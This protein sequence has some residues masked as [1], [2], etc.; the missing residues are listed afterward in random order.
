MQRGELSEL[1]QNLDLF[2]FSL[3]LI[4]RSH[5][6]LCK[7]CIENIKLWKS[8]NY[9]VMKNSI[10]SEYLWAN[11]NIFFFL[12]K[13]FNCR[14]DN[15]NSFSG[16]K[17]WYST[18]DHAISVRYDKEFFVLLSWSEY[19]PFFSRWLMQKSKLLELILWDNVLYSMKKATYRLLSPK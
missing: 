16:N 3:L 15:I 17:S 10:E 8:I 18:E 12:H 9:H 14:W 1:F 19:L 5:I 11:E 7:K 4:A 13:Y 2:W 6:W